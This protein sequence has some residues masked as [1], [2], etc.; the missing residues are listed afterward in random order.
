MES[1]FIFKGDIIK[2]K[3][4]LCTG[5]SG[6]FG[7]AFIK[8]AL[9]QDVKRI[10]VFSRDELKQYEM[11]QE[12]KDDRVR[13]FL[14]DIR[15]KQRLVTAFHGIDI[16]V[17]AAALKQVPALEYDSL[18]GVKTNI[19]GSQNIIEAAIET[20]VKKV[21][22]LSSDKAVEPLNLYGATKLVSEK[23]FISGNSYASGTATKMSC[24]RYGNVI[25]SRGSVIPL[26][27]QQAKSKVLKVTDYRMTRFFI[28]LDK[29]TD[30]VIDAIKSMDGAE[31][32]I[33]RMP[34]CTIEE[35]A[36]VIADKYNCK[37]E[38]IGIRPGEKLHEKLIT[39]GEVVV[40]QGSRYIVI[41]SFGLFDRGDITGNILHDFEYSSDTNDFLSK[42]E[43]SKVVDTVDIGCKCKC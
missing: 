38:E 22:A 43:I 37:I 19:I 27:L 12:L 25:A 10:V 13:Y 16:C 21:I 39:K 11:Q 9:S 32:F 4:I 17:A 6:S 33:P 24:V 18:E 26:F 23:L 7:K 14:G 31:I 1:F 30:F 29:A 41:P 40:N 5:G 20:G 34:S 42:E 36:E 28:T 35:I 8:K 2:G 15:D 3:N